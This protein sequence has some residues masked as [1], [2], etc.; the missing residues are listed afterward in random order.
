MKLKTCYGDIFGEIEVSAFSEGEDD[1]DR[2]DPDEEE[3][4]SDCTCGAWQYGKKGWYLIADCV[5]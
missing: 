1:F 2:F 5:C 3:D 4:H